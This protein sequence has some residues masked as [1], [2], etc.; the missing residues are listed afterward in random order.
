MFLS[1]CIICAISLANLL[2]YCCCMFFGFYFGLEKVTDNGVAIM[3]LVP[4]CC[5]VA[6]LSFLVFV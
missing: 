1:I 2:H 4:F 3:Y 6:F 5:K